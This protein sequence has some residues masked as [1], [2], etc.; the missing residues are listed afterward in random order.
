MI[1]ERNSPKNTF[2]YI[3]FST[4][5]ICIYIVLTWFLA[6]SFMGR[7]SLGNSDED[8]LLAALRLDRGNSAYHYL[9]ARYYQMNLISP[10]IGK[11]IGHYRESIRISPL[12]ANVWI[13]LAKA[14]RTNGQTAE[15]ERSFERAVRLSPDNPA[16]M[17]EAGTFW[18]I[19]NRPDKAVAALKRYLFLAPA[20]Q[21]DVY[22]LCWD[23]QLGNTYILQNLL[24]EKYEYRS[25]YLS[26]LISTGR[27]AEAHETWKTIDINKLDKDL[28][29]KYVNFLILSGIYDEAWAIWK[30]VTGKIEGI[31]NNDDTPPVWNPGFEREILNGG[32]DWTISEV[33]G[34]NVFLD[35]SVRMSGDRSLGI[36]FDGLHNPDI[37]AARQVVRVQPSSKYSLKG[38]VRTD[39]LTTA[40]GIFLNVLGHKCSGPNK[41]SEV[42]N[43]TVFWKEIS[44]DFETPADCR[45]I[46]IAIRR[47]RSNKFDNKIE[48]TAWIDGI[49]MKQQA[50]L[51]T[52]NSARP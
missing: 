15:S 31:E 49:T 21:N 37:T 45:A 18:L 41:K 51:Q 10:D 38:Y 1:N 48:G 16:L 28:F 35:D 34:A 43:G 26:Y 40:N 25:G 9:L 14:Y 2:S 27:A 8:G 5:A 44:V 22:G 52:S 17:W 7:L 30:E 33:E 29:I 20:K 36:S 13:D 12:Q 11:A 23:L 3:V 24:P 4:A 47:E 39:S 32:F 6:K 42:V 50:A 46:T 19:N